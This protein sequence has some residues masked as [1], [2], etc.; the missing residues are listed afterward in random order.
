MSISIKLDDE[1]KDRIQHIAGLQH[2]TPHAVMRE[3]IAQYAEREEAR[4]RFTQEALT[5][6]QHY[7]QTGRHLNGDEVRAWLS[8]WGT[9]DEHPAPECHD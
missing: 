4:E 3:A 7:Q 1:L 5:S 9:D 8:A 2:R 6:W